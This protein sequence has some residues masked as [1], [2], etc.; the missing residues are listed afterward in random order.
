MCRR[1]SGRRISYDPAVDYALMK[2][3]HI[4]AQALLRTPNSIPPQLWSFPSKAGRLFSEVVLPKYA[5]RDQSPWA[6]CGDSKVSFPSFLP[7]NGCFHMRFT[8]VTT[9]FPKLHPS[10][11]VEMHVVP[12]GSQVL[13]RDEFVIPIGNRSPNT[14]VVADR[15]N[16]LFVTTTAGERWVIMPS[17]SRVRDLKTKEFVMLGSSVDAALRTGKA[18]RGISGSAVLPRFPAEVTPHTCLSLEGGILKTRGG[19]S[20]MISSPKVRLHSSLDG[21]K[22]RDQGRPPLAGNE[23]TVFFFNNCEYKTLIAL[24]MDRPVH[25]AFCVEDRKSVFFREYTGPKGDI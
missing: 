8:S 15:R 9:N 12:R 23:A 10:M 24:C 13:H 6:Y 5:K 4:A 20:A 1:V 7:P 19:Q 21:V 2:M 3:S 22:Q 14:L 11:S 18:V 25:V 16:F 17:K